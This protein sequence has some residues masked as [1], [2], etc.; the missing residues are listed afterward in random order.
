MRN[1]IKLI[2]FTALMA[3]IVLQ[4]AAQPAPPREDVRG[5]Q[6]RPNAVSNLLH[7]SFAAGEKHFYRVSNLT[8]A[9][10]Y[11][12]WRDQDNSAN[13]SA[14]VGDIKVSIINLST[15][16]VIVSG[17]DVNQTLSEERLVNTI[18]IRRGTHYN[19]GNEILIIVE[20]VVNSDSG[21]YAI[22][23]Y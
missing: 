4:A 7:R 22:I 15:N 1:S 10:Y 6:P 2:S 5:L 3:V 18:E 23:V 20:G 17:I 14:P 21:N 13:L 16:R 19:N 8:D 9:F 11:V 12:M